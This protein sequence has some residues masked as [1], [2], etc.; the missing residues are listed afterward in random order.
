MQGTQL[1]IFIGI[2]TAI[3]C[4]NFGKSHKFDSSQS[5]KIA[6]LKEY[7]NAAL[8]TIKQLNEYDNSTLHDPWPLTISMREII[9]KEI[10]ALNRELNDRYQINPQKMIEWEQRTED[11]TTDVDLIAER[12]LTTYCID[13]LLLDRGFEACEKK[14]TQFAA[15]ETIIENIVSYVYYYKFDGR[16][17]NIRLLNDFGQN[18][19]DVQLILEVYKPLADLINANTL[20]NGIDELIDLALSVD[21]KIIRRISADK[22]RDEGIDVKNKLRDTIKRMLAKVLKDAVFDN[23]I[24]A[25]L[26]MVYAVDRD[27]FFDAITLAMD[28]IYDTVSTTHILDCLKSFEMAAQTIDGY[29]ALFYKMKYFHSDEMVELAFHI[30]EFRKQ[31]I[32]SNYSRLVWDLRRR[33]EKLKYEFPKSLSALAFSDSVCMRNYQNGEYM[34]AA[35]YTDDSDDRRFVLTLDAFTPADHGT[36]KIER[37]NGKLS[38][39]N[40]FYQEYLFFSKHDVH[41]YTMFTW[42]HPKYDINENNWRIIST[43]TGVKLQSVVDESVYIASSE[44]LFKED[45]YH[46]I[47]AHADETIGRNDHWVL[48]EC[49]EYKRE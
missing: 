7:L 8:E 22:I 20:N 25:N 37:K 12:M 13:R 18:L 16:S 46:V 45:R 39:K 35:K 30:Q 29:T 34:V 14:L 4:F 3:F 5:E 21:K 42:R 43:R 28:S 33:F 32:S 26:S 9:A 47:A 40:D 1:I 2:A 17:K 24:P 41:N 27:L 6:E 10:V 36:W 49:S 48:E 44:K 19:N 38:I 31:S 15:N 23:E 11:L